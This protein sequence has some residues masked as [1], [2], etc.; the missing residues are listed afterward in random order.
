MNILE[1]YFLVQ[2]TGLTDEVDL[3]K[4]D[5]LSTGFCLEKLGGKD[6]IYQDGKGSAN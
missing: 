1:I 4:K 3:K 5:G 2:S 6:T